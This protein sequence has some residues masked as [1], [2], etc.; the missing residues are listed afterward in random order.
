MAFKATLEHPKWAPSRLREALKAAQDG[1][2]MARDGPRGLQ[3]VSKT[4]PDAPKRASR[5][6]RRGQ[7]H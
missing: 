3:E 7:H 6:A 1:S 4:A 5:E 2:K